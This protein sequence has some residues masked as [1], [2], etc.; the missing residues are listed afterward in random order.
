MYKQ[1]IDKLNHFLNSVNVPRTPF[2][3]NAFHGIFV[4]NVFQ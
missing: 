2:N 4:K 1:I 3:P